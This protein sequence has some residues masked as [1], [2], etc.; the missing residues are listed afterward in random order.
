MEFHKCRVILSNRRL[1]LARDKKQRIVV[2]LKGIF[3]VGKSNIPQ[4]LRDV[5]K[6]AVS[7]GYKVDAGANVLVIKADDPVLDRFR[8][9]LYKSLL[10]NVTVE[11]RHPA[12]IGGRVAESNWRDGKLRVKGGSL[13]VG[14]IVKL[15]INGVSRVK[16][17]RVSVRDG[18]TNVLNIDH[19]TKKGVVTTQLNISSPR[20]L[21]IVGR[22]IRSEYQ[23]LSQQAQDLELSQGEKEIMVGLYSG[24]VEDQLPAVL[25]KDTQEVTMMLKSLMKKGVLTMTEGGLELTNKGMI[26]ANRKLEDVNV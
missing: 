8:Q 18:D 2:P 23:R 22:F 11:V 7:I 15:D 1:I 17:E 19:A 13:I 12:R 26:V 24:V 9:I 20:H 14:D 25:G 4:E 16:V 10:N 5:I 3:D 21:N 6:N